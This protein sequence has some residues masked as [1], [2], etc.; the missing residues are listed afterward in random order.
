LL[1]QAGWSGGVVLLA[2]S[3]I[4]RVEPV[5]ECGWMIAAVPGGLVSVL[6]TSKVDPVCSWYV[7][8]HVEVWRAEAGRDF[9][10]TGTGAGRDCEILGKWCLRSYRLASSDWVPLQ[11]RRCGSVPDGPKWLRVVCAK[12]VGKISECLEQG[13]GKEKQPATRMAGTPGTGAATTPPV[14]WGSGREA[15]AGRR[16]PSRSLPVISSPS[17]DAVRCACLTARR[18]TRWAAA[19]SLGSPLCYRQT[20]P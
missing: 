9:V 10:L 7:M 8:D 17:D 16:E 13:K 4:L 20:C 18:T 1:L 6:N 5:L 2:Q 19:D 12:V 14:S 11:A 3:S 15:H